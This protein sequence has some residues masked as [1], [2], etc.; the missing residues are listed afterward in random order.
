M[1]FIVALLF[2]TSSMATLAQTKASVS[3]EYREITS[4]CGSYNFPCMPYS[5]SSSGPTVVTCKVEQKATQ[6][7]VVS[8]QEKLAA[9]LKRV[10]WPKYDSPTIS[11]KTIGEKNDVAQ[12][13]ARVSVRAYTGSAVSEDMMEAIMREIN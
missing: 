13:V 5:S 8:V 9:M 1:K 7:T 4:S 6:S 3:C 10:D 2:I 11:C 12:C